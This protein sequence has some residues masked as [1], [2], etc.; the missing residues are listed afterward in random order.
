MQTDAE[1][2]VNDGLGTKAEGKFR[3]KKFL[4]ND[5]Y[6]LGVNYTLIKLSLKNKY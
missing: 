3:H 1:L 6:I 4:G 5:R 2:R